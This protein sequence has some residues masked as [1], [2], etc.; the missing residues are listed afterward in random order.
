MMNMTYFP[1]LD[2]FK[3]QNDYKELATENKDLTKEEIYQAIPKEKIFAPMIVKDHLFRTDGM[4]LEK[5]DESLLVVYRLMKNGSTEKERKEGFNALSFGASKVDL[6]PMLYEWFCLNKNTFSYWFP[7]L[8]KSFKDS[9]NH[10]F[11]IP[12]TQYTILPIELSQFMRIEYQDTD[13]ES[14]EVFNRVL[15]NHFDLS[16]DEEYFIKTGTFSSK[17]EFRN[18]HIQK[19]EASE[20]GEYFQ[21]INNFAMFVGAGHTNDVVIREYID[22]IENR[23]TIY[24]GMPLRTEFRL[25]IDCDKGI[26]YGV[27]PYWNGYVMKSVLQRQGQTNPDILQDYTTY[28]KNEDMLMKDFNDHQSKVKQEVEQMMPWLSKNFNGKW[29]LDIMKNGNDFYLIDMALAEQSAMRDLVDMDWKLKD[30]N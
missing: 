10:F 30:N 9:K 21:V 11:K 5:I 6:T 16:D 12:K 23:P 19:G 1:T 15:F 25:F 14:R 29:S 20:I 26:V 27:V 4:P 2:D 3:K 7:R 28:V 24:H 17:F 22:D 18:A 8:E 13:K